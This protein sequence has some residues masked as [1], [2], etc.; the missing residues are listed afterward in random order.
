MLYLL[1]FFIKKIVKI[2][3]LK[4]CLHFTFHFLIVLYT[5]ID[6]NYQYNIVLHLDRNAYHEPTLPHLSS[7]QSDIMSFSALAQLGLADAFVG[8]HDPSAMQSAKAR[9]P[10][11]HVNP[12]PGFSRDPPRS[13]RTKKSTAPTKEP[14]TPTKEPATPTKEPATIV[15]SDADFPSIRKS[16][17]KPIDGPL[18][19]WATATN[20]HVQCD[21]EPEKISI[22]DENFPSMGEGPKTS[23]ALS[24]WVTAVKKPAQKPVQKPVQKPKSIR[25]TKKTGSMTN[26]EPFNTAMRDTTLN[27]LDVL[28]YSPNPQK[29]DRNDAKRL[30]RRKVHITYL[31]DMPKELDDLLFNTIILRSAE[32]ASGIMTFNDKTW[33][34]C[35]AIKVYYYRKEKAVGLI[36]DFGRIDHVKLQSS[37]AELTEFLRF[38]IDDLASKA[39]PDPIED[40]QSEAIVDEAIVDEAIVDYATE[41]APKDGGLLWGAQM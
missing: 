29:G 2:V 15:V 23:P 27:G 20:K 35:D 34:P 33:I 31:P 11:T 26:I 12:P 24:D 4:Y 22:S 16:T 3:K 10:H 14:A 5:K 19:G 18:T 39:T 13:R 9:T 32:L 25:R 6:F 17:K 38:V 8:E 37:L 1:H 7:Q 40:S 36:F 28:L 41:W 21:A 30:D